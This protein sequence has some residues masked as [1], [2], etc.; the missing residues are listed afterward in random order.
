MGFTTNDE[1]A[2]IF[3]DQLWSKGRLSGVYQ[4]SS[5]VELDLLYAEQYDTG[6][7]GDLW[8]DHHER[9]AN[10]IASNIDNQPI[11]EIGGAHS[12][13]SVES[14][15]YGFDDWTIIEPAPN[16]LSGCNAVI[17]QG[18]FDAETKLSNQNVLVHPHVLEHV[19]NP[20]NFL[21]L[22]HNQLKAHGVIIFSVQKIHQIVKHNYSNA[23]NFEHTIFLTRHIID[24]M[25]SKVGFSIGA[26]KFFHPD[27]SSFYYCTKTLPNPTAFLRL[28]TDYDVIFRK[29]WGKFRKDIVQVN[30]V[31]DDLDG[32]FL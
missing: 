26:I 1:T 25:L 15:R 2:D 14:A 8:K 28:E 9:L 5:L 32:P 22:C 7:I 23:F 10:F 17:H 19:Y 11:F 3:V 21:Q 18:F 20:L 6:V 4:L 13:L 29:Y 16:P 27:H 12:I 31:I 24:F 30:G